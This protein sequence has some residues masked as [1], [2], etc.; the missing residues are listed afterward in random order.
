MIYFSTLIRFSTATQNFYLCFELYAF[1]RTHR[2]WKPRL[3]PKILQGTGEHI[4][5]WLVHHGF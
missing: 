1:N 3:V 4:S 2:P 5:R